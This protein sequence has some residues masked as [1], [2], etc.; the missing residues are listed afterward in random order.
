MF[1]FKKEKNLL[2]KR[3]EN[4]KSNKYKFISCNEMEKHCAEEI[5]SNS[6][7][8]RKEEFFPPRNDTTNIVGTCKKFIS[9]IKS[10]FEYFLN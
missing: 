10:S 4:C 2:H 7:R 5:L 3:K 9:V 8:N 1:D 6:F